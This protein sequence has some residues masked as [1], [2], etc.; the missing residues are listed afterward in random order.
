MP[1][2]GVN[3]TSTLATCRLEDAPNFQLG[4]RAAKDIIARHIGVIR[5]AWDDIC[6]EAELTAVERNL[7]D[8]HIFLDDH[9]FEETPRHLW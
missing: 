6:E 5:D 9:V 1:V 7:S 8:R 2:V 3:R 4:E